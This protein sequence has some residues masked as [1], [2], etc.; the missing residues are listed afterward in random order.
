MPAPK[1]C[2]EVPKITEASGVPYIENV[3]KVP[4]V[5]FKLLEVR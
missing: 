4:L 5:I 1:A 2:I 3:A